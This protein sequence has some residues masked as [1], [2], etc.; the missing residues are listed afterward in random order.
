MGARCEE[1]YQPC[2]ATVAILPFRLPDHCIASEH[3]LQNGTTRTKDA[4]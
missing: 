1:A 4:I 2:Y 3:D